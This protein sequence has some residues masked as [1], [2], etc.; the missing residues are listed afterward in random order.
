M[1]AIEETKNSLDAALDKENI[2]KP[3]TPL[4]TP[5]AIVKTEPNVASTLPAPAQPKLSQDQLAEQKLKEKKDAKYSALLEK[6]RCRTH[7]CS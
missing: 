2:A 4:A 3:D 6:V 7:L 1:K 5:P